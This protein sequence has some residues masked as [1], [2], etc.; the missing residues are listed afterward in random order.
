[1]AAEAQIAEV[2]IVVG[3]LL[4]MLSL[5]SILT[6]LADGR[7]PK[8]GAAVLLCALGLLA[9]AWHLTPG[10]LTL[11]DI[12]FAFYHLIGDWRH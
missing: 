2:Q 1:M 3:T 5:P 9:H 8:V 4:A 11:R 6:A 10:G 7:A 12:P